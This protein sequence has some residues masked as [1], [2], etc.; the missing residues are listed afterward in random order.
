MIMKGI[1]IRIFQNSW[2]ALKNNQIEIAALTVI[3]SVYPSIFYSWFVIVMTYQLVLELIKGLRKFNFKILSSFHRHCIA[4]YGVLKLIP[5]LKINTKN[6][7]REIHRRNR[8]SF[9]TSES[10]NIVYLRIAIVIELT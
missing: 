6:L 9:D 5:R 2:F 10:Q 8:R 7:N 3:I 4:L 1:S